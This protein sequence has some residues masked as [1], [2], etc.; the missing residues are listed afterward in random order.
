MISISIASKKSLSLTLGPNICPHRHSFRIAFF[1]LVAIAAVSFAYPAFAQQGFSLIGTWQRTVSTE[2]QMLTFK[3]DGTFYAQTAV[4]PGPYGQGSG[5][6]K[7]WG[8]YGMKG[9]TS[10]VATIQVFQVCASG[11]ACMSC[12]PAPGDFP[13]SNTC[14]V[15]QSLGLTPGVQHERSFQIQGPNQFVDQFGQT[16]RRVR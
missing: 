3:T 13:G 14:G 16:W 4:P 5:Y 2:V 9:A 15:A 12:P 1:A 11:V 6:T 7:W 8:M 10:W